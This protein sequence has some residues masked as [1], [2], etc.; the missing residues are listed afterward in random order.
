MKYFE[1]GFI[2]GKFMPLHNGHVFLIDTAITQCEQVTICVLSQPGEPIS[3]EVRLA[4]ITE[5]YPECTVVHH[6]AVLPRDDTGYD[7]WD[8][9]LES[10]R[11]HCPDGYDAVFSSEQYGKRL[12]ADFSAQHVQVDQARIVVP[13]SGTAIRA[14][15]EKH[16]E[17][18]P[19]IVKTYYE[20][21]D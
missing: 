10:I 7:N 12:A 18:L 21:Q 5:L 17:Y 15:P 11:L 14:N 8:V 9:W 2:V 13:V 16:F 19:A 3:G 4:W 6:Q 1:H 20:N